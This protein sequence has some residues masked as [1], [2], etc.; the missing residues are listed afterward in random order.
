[1][2]AILFGGTGMIGQAVLR[3]L[4]SRAEV[5]HVLAVGRTPLE[6]KDPKLGELLRKDLFDY[7][8]VGDAFVGFDAVFFCL[9]VSSGGMSEA[10]YRKV[11]LELPLAAARAI[12]AKSPQATFCFISGAGTDSSEKGK[13]MWARVKGEA[14]NRLQEV[15]F[16]AV[17]SFRPGFIYPMDGETSKTPS[18]RLMYAVTKPF[19]PL[20]WGFTKWVTTTRS[21]S[22]AMVEVAKHGHSKKILENADLDHFGSR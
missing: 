22:Y 7:G 5:T 19:F 16:K 21:L 4:L 2:R 17:Y 1:M 12:C 11:S 10:E 15:G 3:E 14:E 6:K 13:T 9:G 20:F 8:D 18:Y